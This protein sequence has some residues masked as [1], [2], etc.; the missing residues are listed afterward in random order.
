LFVT[1]YF[2]VFIPPQAQKQASK[3]QTQPFTSSG[4]YTARKR[5]GF[6]R[7]KSLAELRKSHKNVFMNLFNSAHPD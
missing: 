4:I 2:A 1:K 5:E 6:E 3:K 7:M